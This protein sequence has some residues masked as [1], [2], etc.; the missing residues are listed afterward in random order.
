MNFGLA[1]EIYGAAAWHTDMETLPSLLSI[2]D[3][4][5]KLEVPEVKSNT[6]GIF[7]LN[8][9]RLIDRPYGNSW[10]PGQL[11]NSDKFS[12]IGII[13]V[14]GPITVNGGQSSM[15]MDQVSGIMHKM[16]ADDRINSFLLLGNSSGGSSHAVEIMTDTINEIDK[17]KPVYGLVKKAGLACSAMYGIMSAC[18]SIYAESEMSFVGSCGT[19]IQFEGR[20]ANT[21]VD[22]IKHI[23]LYASKSVEKNGPIEEALNNDNYKLIYDELLNPINERFLGLIESNRPVLKNTGFD[24]GRAVFAKDAVGTYIDGIKSMAEVV[25]MIENDIKEMPTPASQVKGINPINKDNVMTAEQ[26]KQDHP[27]T[28]QSVFGAGVKSEASRTQAWMAHANADLEKVQSGIKTG[29]DIS[30]GD[31]EELMIKAFSNKHV[32][33]IEADS[34]EEVATPESGSPEAE[35][36]SELDQFNARVNEKL[37][38]L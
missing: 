1:R 10:S 27:E 29:E 4:Q 33:N 15:G 3:N 12:G 13:N 35:V 38:S 2:L 31:R 37:K 14:D 6:P 26:L 21:E 32:E 16:A 20:A 23:R 34:A 22:G 17:S 8:E 36:E 24:T 30:S 18:R 9:T 7:V 28:Y 5:S 19:M 11:E 25:Q